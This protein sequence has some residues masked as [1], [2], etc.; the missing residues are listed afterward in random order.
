MEE[1]IIDTSVF[2]LGEG[3]YFT[4]ALKNSEKIFVKTDKAE[5]REAKFIGK[6]F[7]INESLTELIIFFSKLG[8][9]AAIT[10]NE[11]PKYNTRL[12]MLC[13]MKRNRS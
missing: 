4:K 12:T 8:D 6:V 10:I 3:K 7:K 9:K 5:I 11:A 1:L 2:G 13:L